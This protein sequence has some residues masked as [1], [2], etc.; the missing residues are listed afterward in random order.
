MLIQFPQSQQGNQHIL[1]RILIRQK[2]FP[3]LI[4]HIIPPNQLHLIRLQLM[5]DFLNTHF[6]RPHIPASEI[7]VFHFLQSQLAQIAV[8]NPTGHQGHRDIPLNTVH[9]RPGRHQSQQFR[10]DLHQLIRVVILIF[11]AAPQFIQT[12]A[13]DHQR[14]VQ[15][16]PVRAKIG[17]LEEFSR[18][19]Q[20]PLH[21]H[22]GQIRHQV[23]H[24]LEPRILGQLKAA[25]DVLHRVATVGIPRHILIN[26]LHTDFQAGT[27]IQ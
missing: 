6:P 21:T 17:V 23:G 18:G 4:S 20:V 19:F 25:L 8:F 27:A 24:H 9:T 12:G 15:L 3:P 22:I 7:H 14:G 10:H 11:P 13:S 16:Q 1:F 26:R 2:G 5:V